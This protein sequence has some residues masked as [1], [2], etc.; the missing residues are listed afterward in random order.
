MG[1]RRGRRDSFGSVVADAAYIA[2]RRGPEGALWFGLVCF[3]IFYVLLPW[4]FNG[5]ANEAAANTG[6]LFGAVTRQ[7]VDA[8][9]FHR[10][11]HP[12]EL[13]G[14]AILLVC[15]MIAAWKFF[16]GTQLA[17]PHERGLSSLSRWLARWLD[18]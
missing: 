11:V 15:S 16:M 18:N 2:N 9:F 3:W 1:Y 10:L 4:W 5:L 14:I 7:L 8:V 13:T 6:S 17:S 12:S